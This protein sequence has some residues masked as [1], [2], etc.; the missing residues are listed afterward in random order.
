MLCQFLPN[1]PLHYLKDYPEYASRYIIFGPIRLAT[2][3]GKTNSIK[4]FDFFL[5]CSNYFPIIDDLSYAL[6]RLDGREEKDTTGWIPLSSVRNK[7]K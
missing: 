3:V 5:Y 2:L 1:A 6:L 4:P 7:V